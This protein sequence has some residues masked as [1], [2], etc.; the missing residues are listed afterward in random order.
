MPHLLLMVPRAVFKN[1]NAQTSKNSKS[2]SRDRK[3]FS[4]INTNTGGL[5]SKKRQS[6]KT[7]GEVKKMLTTHF[8]KPGFMRTACSPEN[9]SSL[10]IRK[11]NLTGITNSKNTLSSIHR[12]KGDTRNSNTLYRSSH[13][14]EKSNKNKLKNHTSSKMKSP[15]TNSLVT[16]N[17]GCIQKNS[18]KDKHRQSHRTNILRN[19]IDNPKILKEKLTDR[20]KSNIAKSED[21]HEGSDILHKND[22][23]LLGLKKKIFN[24]IQKSH[25]N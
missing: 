17:T 4:D 15:S 12:E 25:K 22:K 9:S 5:K 8:L 18:T 19:I 3:K 2:T 14:S 24:S 6:I 11:N 21:D 10:S 23:M 13:H 1:K 7:H 16:A 20:D